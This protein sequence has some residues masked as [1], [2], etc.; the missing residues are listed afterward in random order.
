MSEKTLDFTYYTNY[1]FVIKNSIPKR[2]YFLQGE[3]QMSIIKPD[4]KLTLFGLTRQEAA[5]Y[6]TL[7]REDVPLTGYEIAKLTGISRSNV[8]AAVGALTDK[9]AAYI[10]EGSPA[11]Y[12]PVSPKEFC[13]NYLRKLEGF[14]EELQ[15]EL[16]TATHRT[17]GY[18]T[19]NG[20]QRIMDTVRGMLASVRER[21]YIAAD[22]EFISD[23]AADLAGLLEREMKVVI[24]TPETDLLPEGVISYR[25][26]CGK[27]Q[28]RIIADG[29]SVL[30]GELCRDGSPCS[31]LFSTKENLVSVLK[32][33][34]KNQI[35][36]IRLR[37]EQIN[38]GAGADN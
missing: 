28:I 9:G 31:C 25:A 33:S 12:S 27:G 15:K 14:S 23:I 26:D 29:A 20:S 22:S 34:L 3:T 2:Y 4:D 38:P 21:V 35:E 13:G 6:R 36:L 18:I 1:N 11:R 16:P 19:V 7:C 5:I 24:I 17:D 30:T 10:M 32:E 37:E 8:Y